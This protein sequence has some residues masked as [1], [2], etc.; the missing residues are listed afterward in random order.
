MAVIATRLH[1]ATELVPV[2]LG[3]NRDE[4][5]T[6]LA[7]KPEHARLLFGKLP[8]L[9]N[10]AKYVAESN[11]FNASVTSL[12]ARRPPNVRVSPTASSTLVTPSAPEDGEPF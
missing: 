2:I 1:R 9:R 6:F 8:L 5:R 3:S 4:Y 11:A 10:R 7:D 12:T